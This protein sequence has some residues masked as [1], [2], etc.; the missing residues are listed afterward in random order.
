M[1]RE[2][3]T[4]GHSISYTRAAI[5]SKEQSRP[6][7]SEATLDYNVLIRGGSSDLASSSF[8]AFLES[9]LVFVDDGLVAS[10][11]RIDFIGAVL[12][13]TA[14]ERVARGSLNA[15]PRERAA[16]PREDVDV[17]ELN[18]EK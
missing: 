16:S 8:L 6:V 1:G 11:V 18:L 3:K 13:F 17:G 7:Y 9:S 14:R 12:V 10:E 5:V 15:V 4:N 2:D